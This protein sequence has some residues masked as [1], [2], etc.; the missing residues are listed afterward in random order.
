MS[1]PACCT[2]LLIVL[3]STGRALAASTSTEPLSLDVYMQRL[4]TLEQ[5]IAA[6]DTRETDAATR[7]LA[8]LDDSWSVRAGDRTFHVPAVWLQAGLAQWALHPSPEDRA[9]LVRELRLLREEA[10]AFEQTVGDRSDRPETRAQLARILA[11]KEFRNVR[12][13]GVFDDLRRRVVLWLLAVL[14]RLLGSASASAIGDVAAYGLV[15][16]VVALVTVIMVRLLRSGALHDLH[17]M[18]ATSRVTA[19][20]IASIED[21]HRAAAAGAW[22]DAVRLAYWSGVGSLEDRGLWRVD[23]SRTPREYLR[24]VPVGNEPGTS[25][26]AFTRLLERVWYA[27][28]PAGPADFAA[29]LEH[30]ERL[31]WPV[32]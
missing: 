30:F 24:L 7:L 15:A 26:G 1:R 20:R 3:L 23:R 5:A 10:A 18:S 32:P 14:S 2:A 6:L 11:Q 16:L 27:N 29:A 17:A 19:T 31:T 22:R 13:P 12:S 28:E 8:G 4:T 25:L 21:A 9:R